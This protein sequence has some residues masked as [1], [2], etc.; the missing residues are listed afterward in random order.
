MVGEIAGNVTL[1]DLEEAE[2]LGIPLAEL[3][4]RRHVDDL[5]GRIKHLYRVFRYLAE[6]SYRELGSID[7]HI[8]ADVDEIVRRLRLSGVS[9]SWSC[10]VHKGPALA[11][12]SCRGVTYHLCED[13]NEWQSDVPVAKAGADKL[14]E[15]RVARLEDLLSD[16]AE[17]Q[18]S[19]CEHEPGKSCGFCEPAD[20]EMP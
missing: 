12:R 2:A 14:L 15:K 5:R 7:E 13:C 18:C 9:A 11:S 10:P 17:I 16:L 19:V 6:G 4:W 8:Q 20:L 3:R 1:E